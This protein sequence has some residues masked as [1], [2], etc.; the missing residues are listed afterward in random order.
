LR[1]AE[2][3]KIA[4]GSSVPLTRDRLAEVRGRD[5]VTGLPRLAT[6]STTEIREALEEPVASIVDAVKVTL[7]RTPPELA[8]DIMEHGI[9]LAGGGALLVGLPELLYA[10]TGMPVRLAPDPLLA[11]VLGAGRALEEFEL[12]GSVIFGDGNQ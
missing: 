9:T 6:I 7:D 12:F 3:I 10:E 1:A 2:E 8:A 4:L 11:V 5:L